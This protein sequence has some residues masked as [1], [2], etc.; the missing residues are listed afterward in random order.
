MPYSNFSKRIS[1]LG[2]K[3]HSEHWIYIFTVLKNSALGEDL[4]WEWNV[5]PPPVITEEV[6]QSIEELIMKRISEGHFDDVQKV[7]KLPSKA[8][9]EMKE[10]VKHHKLLYPTVF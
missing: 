3:Q 4:D 8:P 10:L 1:S 5:K 7:N 2:L 6:S 9:R